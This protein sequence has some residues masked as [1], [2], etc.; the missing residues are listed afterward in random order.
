MLYLCSFRWLLVH[1]MIRLFNV[2][3]AR[4]TW[5]SSNFSNVQLLGLF[6]DIPNAAEVTTLPVHSRAMFKAAVLL[7]QQYNITVQGQFIGWQAAETGGDA[8]AALGN[9]CRIM[10]TSKIVGIVDPVFS[11]EARIGAAFANTIGIPVISYAA[12]DP[13]LS[14]RNAFPAFYRTIPSDTTAALSIAKLFIRFNWTSCIIVYQ[15]DEFGSGGMNAI[16]QAFSSNGLAVEET[17]IFDIL[18]LRIRDDLKSTL[19]SS[20]TRI[21]L[22]WAEP[23]YTSL[24]LQ[25]ALDHDVLGP[26]FVWILRSSVPLS[27]F[28]RTSDKPLIGMF[29]VEPVVGSVVSAPIN[30]TLLNAAY[31]IWQHY[32]P[33][34]FPGATEVEN[35]ALFA[36]DATWS[37][38]QSL[39]QLCS[40]STNSSPSCIAVVNSSFCFDSHFLNANS[41]FNAIISTVFLGVSGR[42]QFSANVTDRINGT[43]YVAQNVQPSGNGMNYVSVLKWSDP[44]DWKAYSQVD[45]IVWPG[46]S[47]VTPTGRAAL[48]D[49]NLRIVVIE[50]LPFTMLK[51]VTD[52]FGHNT[53]KLIGYV[54]DLIDLLKNSMGFI[55][56]ITLAPSNQTYAGLILAVANGVYDMAIGDITVTAERRKIV[57]FSTSIFDNSLRIIIR[58]AP[59]VN[60]D[61]LSYLKP[62]SLKVW[63]TLLGVSIYAAILFWLLERHKNEALR[64]KSNISAGVMSAWFSVGTILGYGADFRATTAAGRLL[65]IGLYILC[66]ILVATYTANLASDLTISKSKYVIS[67]IDDIKN[68]KIPFGRIGILVDSSIEDYYLQ[69][70]SGGSRNFYPIQSQKEL[71]EKL[72]SKVIDA[73]IMDSGLLEYA[74]NDIYCNLTLVGADFGESAYGIA[75]PKQWLYGQTLDVNILSLR[76]SGA[77]DNLYKTWFETSTCAASSSVVSVGVPLQ[78]MGGLFLTFVVISVLSLLLFAWTR[79]FTIKNYLTR[80]HPKTSSGQEHVTMERPSIITSSKRPQNSE[81]TA[82][83]EH[84]F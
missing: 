33:E 10:S 9:S 23:S 7:S 24:I 12:T 54:P 57:D 53:T 28:N 31:N 65:T 30:T 37:L 46:N 56:N 66:L 68:G 51:N 34:S 52:A 78:A 27:S 20:T 39:Q 59:A 55:P 32:E 29:G 77:L 35:Y 50:A 2:Q 25:N 61:L 47:L 48:S 16:S 81:S 74:T 63:L 41:F 17:L 67:G 1:F 44:G 22:L 21:V 62:F 36:F 69:E 8:I 79:R 58:Q 64:E 26:Q 14:D 60:V 38:I 76:E 13:G 18:T 4:A 73:G 43:Y 3:Y 11:R 15:N 40:T 42:V 83:A 84:H 72:L 82:S 6:Q 49:V 5:P 75:I 19:S 71:Y 70:I 80:P 45:V